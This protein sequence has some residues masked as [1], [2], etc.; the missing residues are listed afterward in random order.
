MYKTF[1]FAEHIISY[2]CHSLFFPFTFLYS[3]DMFPCVCVYFFS[4][5]FQLTIFTLSL[6]GLFSFKHIHRFTAYHFLF[7][8]TAFVAFIVCS[9]YALILS[10]TY[11]S[12]YTIAST[13]F[14]SNLFIP[15]K[16][17]FSISFVRIR[18]FTFARVGIQS[19]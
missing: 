3:F 19:M 18:R 4:S 1:S 6:W 15:I 16:M 5:L 12:W 14:C 7:F 10:T 17:I 13:H 11:L 8:Y 2:Q 9:C